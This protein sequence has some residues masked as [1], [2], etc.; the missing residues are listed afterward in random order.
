MFLSFTLLCSV[1]TCFGTKPFA[2]QEDLETNYWRHGKVVY[3]YKLKNTGIGATAKWSAVK[4]IE[5]M[6]SCRCIFCFVVLNQH[7][8]LLCS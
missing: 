4:K 1:P 5:Q 8:R 7:S 6:L 3:G 2:V